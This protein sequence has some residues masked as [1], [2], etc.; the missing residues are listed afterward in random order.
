MGDKWPTEVDRISAPGTLDTYAAQNP[1]GRWVVLIRVQYLAAELT[2][3]Q[4][5]LVAESLVG[6]ADRAEEEAQGGLS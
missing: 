1:E 2:P 6:L 4:A 3:A 5:R